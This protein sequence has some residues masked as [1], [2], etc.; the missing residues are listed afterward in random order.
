MFRAALYNYPQ[1]RNSQI[2]IYSEQIV[3][4]HTLECYVAIGMSDV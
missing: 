1:T 3:F 2:P 4:I